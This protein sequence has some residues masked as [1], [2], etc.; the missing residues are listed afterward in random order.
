MS[1]V[2]KDNVT[3]VF[4]KNLTFWKTGETILKHMNAVKSKLHRFILWFAVTSWKLLVGYISLIA[5]NYFFAEILQEINI[6]FV[7]EQ[8]DTYSIKV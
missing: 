4:H 2:G 1:T 3:S 8:C 6:Q 5:C 7:S